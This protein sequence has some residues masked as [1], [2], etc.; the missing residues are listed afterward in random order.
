MTDQTPKGVVVVVVVITVP[1]VETVLPVY[2]EAV[3]KSSCPFFNRF[4]EL[5]FWDN[6]FI[7]LTK[8]K[9]TNRND[10]S[11]ENYFG[12]NCGNRFLEK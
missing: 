4:L 3:P 2:K 5:L 8:I 6:R 11:S 1:T 10:K 7:S 9:Q 12:K